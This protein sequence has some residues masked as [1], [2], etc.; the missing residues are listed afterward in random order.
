MAEPTPGA[1]ASGQTTGAESTAGGAGD[2]EEVAKLRADNTR[3][4]QRI[5]EDE[6]LHKTAVPLV[7]L[8][9]ALID[10]PGGR[11]IVEKL[12]RGEPLTAAETKKVEVAEEATKPAEYLTKGAAEELLKGLLDEA[13]SKFGESVAAERKAAEALS[14]LEARAEKE[15]EG[16]KFLKRDPQYHRMVN[17]VIA[18]IGDKIIEVPDGEDDVWWFAMNAAYRA[19]HALR[20]EPGK[21]KTTKTEEERVAEALASGA[22]PSSTTHTG[23]EG[24][25]PEAL[26]AQVDRIRQYGTR[27]IAGKSFS[28]P[29]K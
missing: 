18:Q 11:E 4:R 16:F 10:A 27:T 26:Q 12:Q 21:K 24:K 1:G 2:G 15:L 14:A 9:R 6:K 20:N 28:G 25:L 7:R 23:D 8:A 22:G 17:D 5:A 29:K 3:L 13:V 19:I